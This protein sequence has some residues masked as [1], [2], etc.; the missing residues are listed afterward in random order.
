M[1]LFSWFLC[2]KKEVFH[3]I[4]CLREIVT[5]NKFRYPTICLGQYIQ[6]L[7]GSINNTE[8]ERSINVLY[9]GQVDNDSGHIVFKV[10]TKVVVSVDSVVVIPTTKTV[11]G[12]IDEMG[13]SEKKPEGIQFTNRDSRVS[14]NNLN[15]NLNNI[16]DNNSNVS[17]KNFNH[18]EDYQ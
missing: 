17:D 16:D 15:L 11:V 7:L 8:L 5:E 2:L 10:D 13:L 3:H 1:L 12:R 14:T 18:D 9:L 4:L 6:K